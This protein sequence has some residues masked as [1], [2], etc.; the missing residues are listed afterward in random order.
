MQI[1]MTMQTLRARRQLAIILTLFVVGAGCGPADKDFRDHR[2]GKEFDE[3]TSDAAAITFFSVSD[4]ATGLLTLPPRRYSDRSES[5]IT[6]ALREHVRASAGREPDTKVYATILMSRYV[7]FLT[8]QTLFDEYDFSVTTTGCA[9]R[10]REASP[11]VMLR[12]T[13]LTTA[14]TKPETYLAALANLSDD[15][16][17]SGDPSAYTVGGFSALTS[18]RSLNELWDAYPELVRVVGISGTESEPLAVPWQF[19]SPTDPL[20]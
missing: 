13:P 10:Y 16:A 3:V 17:D 20:R 8:F 1:P 9:L 19:V 4:D 7:D 11:T 12:N 5:S 2:S 14:L 18:L 15:P 6:T